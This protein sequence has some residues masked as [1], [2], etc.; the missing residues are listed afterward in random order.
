MPSAR[1]SQIHLS[2]HAAED[3]VPFWQGITVILSGFLVGLVFAVLTWKGVIGGPKGFLGGSI[4]PF[5]KMTGLGGALFFWI[6]GFIVA[7]LVGAY[8]FTVMSKGYRHKHWGETFQAYLF[9]SPAFFILLAFGFLP[10]LYAFYISLHRWRVTP[11]RYLGAGNYTQAIGDPISFFIFLFG[12]II[13]LAAWLLWEDYIRPSNCDISAGRKLTMRIIRWLAILI[14]LWIAVY[15]LIGMVH[16]GDEKVF[17]GFLYTVYYSIGTIPLQLAIS[18]VLAYILFQK[19]RGQELFRMLFFMPYIAPS[20][21][22]AAVFTTLFT[23]R[24]EGLVNRLIT[25][26]GIP[27]QKWLFEASPIN[28]II[29]NMFGFHLPVWLGGPS[30]AMV[31]IILYNTWVFFGYYTV[32]F[33]AGLGN[34]PNTLYEAAKID[35]ANQW[36]LFR[37][38]TLPL[39][40]PTTFFLSMIGV[41]GTFKAFNHI[42][43][44][45]VPAALGTVDTVS[46]VIF[47]QFFNATRYG[48][49]SAIAFVLFAVILLLTILQNRVFG[50]KVFY[51]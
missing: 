15:G 28:V 46:I 11:G 37:R 35:G 24:P 40:S 32:I 39:L 6:V 22:T 3:G 12:V 38:I 42:Y 5:R 34:V 2:R 27:A 1:S 23:P 51:S 30:M 49:A 45:R 19:I 13:F 50:R 14:G 7:I 25:T 31:S 33:L 48:Y 47:D 44:M 21:A 41:I 29:A 16:S 9:L 10:V 8:L 17:N 18:L 26:I 43:V 36:V 4:G 20:V